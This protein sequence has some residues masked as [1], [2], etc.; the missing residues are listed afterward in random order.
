MT[1]PQD[2]PPLEPI[3]PVEPPLLAPPLM[4]IP[5]RRRRVAA[6]APAPA[7]VA[8]APRPARRRQRRRRRGAERAADAR[9]CRRRGLAALALLAD[10]QRYGALERRRGP[11]RVTTRHAARSRAQ[12]T[13]CEPHPPRGALH[14]VARQR[15][16]TTSA[17][18]SCST[19]SRRATAASPAVKQLAAVLQVADR[20][21]ACARC[22][23]SSRRPTPRCRS[24]RRCGR[25]SASLLRDRVRSGGGGGGGGGRR[26]RRWRRWRRRRR[27]M[28]MTTTT[29]PAT[30]C[31]STTI[32]IS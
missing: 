29:C 24:S 31:W 23:T 21:S 5:R 18:C 2:S 15:R 28:T 26:R 13:D 11:P 19:T 17:R 22:A 16:R 10:L 12:R 4:P 32:P 8:P 25:W 14:A 1:P 20:R 9:R 27:R 7:A 3:E 30:S 6:P